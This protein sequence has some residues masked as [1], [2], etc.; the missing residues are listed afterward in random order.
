MILKKPLP[1]YVD[2]EPGVWVMDEAEQSTQDE[3]PLNDEGRYQHVEADGREA[4]SL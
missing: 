4:V 3:S 2:G 1:L